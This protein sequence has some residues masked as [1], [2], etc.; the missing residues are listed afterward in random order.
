MARGSLSD[1]SNVVRFPI[2]ARARPTLDLLRELAP[3]VRGVE[4][5]AEAFHLPVPE[6]DFRHRVDAE[7]AEHI[8]NHIDPR[9][10]E[11]RNMA[12]R[13]LRDRVV[14]AALK[15]ARAWRPASVAADDA[16]RQVV[17]ARAEGGYW[18]D[19]LEQQRATLEQEAAALLLEAHLRSEEAEGVARAVRLARSGQVWTPYDSIREAEVLFFGDAA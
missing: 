19:A 13:A 6:A 8:L 12:L 16:Q 14:T 1:T 7:A 4:L 5:T 17:R 9:P 18:M 11:V 10:G 2:E 15:A 3:D